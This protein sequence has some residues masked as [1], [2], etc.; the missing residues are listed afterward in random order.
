MARSQVPYAQKPPPRGWRGQI[1]KQRLR[2][3][4]PWRVLTQKAWDSEGLVSV[5]RTSNLKG[6]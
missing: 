4:P 1:T 5:V 6:F 3:H 2:T